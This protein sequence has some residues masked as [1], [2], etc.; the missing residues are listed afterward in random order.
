M[1]SGKPDLIEAFPPGTPY[2]FYAR[3][4]RRNEGERSTWR[5]LDRCRAFAEEHG[6]TEVVGYSQPNTSGMARGGCRHLNSMMA[7]ARRGDFRVLV[8][9]DLDR[10]SRDIW[11]LSDI[12]RQLQSLNVAIFT[13]TGGLVSEI[14][15]AFHCSVSAHYSRAL[16]ARIRRGKRTAVAREMRKA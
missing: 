2:A 16:G 8:V 4:A 9:E 10:L 14:Q 1:R 7:A 6:W 11:Q 12:F 15:L 5:Q 3:T 13:T